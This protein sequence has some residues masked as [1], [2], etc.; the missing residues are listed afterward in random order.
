MFI[1]KFNRAFMVTSLGVVSAV[2]GMFFAIDQKLDYAILCLV[3]SGICD[4]FDGKI[5][6]KH[7]KTDEDTKYGI[8]IDSLADIFAFGVFPVVILMTMG[9]QEWYHFAIYS[10]FIITGITRLSYFNMMAEK[11]GPVKVFTGLPITSSSMA[12]PFFWLLN[13]LLETDFL[14]IVYPILMFVMAICFVA[15]VKVIKKP[16]KVENIIFTLIAIVGAIWLIFFK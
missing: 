4:M 15:N 11:S 14:N 10:L 6:R 13:V 2:I 3:I 16:G 12:F 8:Q 5:A 7:N 9:L 1:G